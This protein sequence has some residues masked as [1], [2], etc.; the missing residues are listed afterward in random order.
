MAYATRMEWDQGAH[1][2]VLARDGPGGAEVAR[3]TLDAWMELHAVRY[4]VE[5]A[6]RQALHEAEEAR[7]RSRPLADPAGAA[8]TAAL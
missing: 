7:H 2:V 1:W 6:V 5:D 8:A 4:A 3:M